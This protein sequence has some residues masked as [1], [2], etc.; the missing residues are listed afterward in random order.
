MSIISVDKQKCI[1]CSACV[2][3]CPEN[4]IELVM[5]L[6]SGCIAVESALPSA[7]NNGDKCLGCGQCVAACPTAALD[8]SRARLFSSGTD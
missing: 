5:Q 4:V 3:V 7:Q 2:S 8:N 1:S 6:G